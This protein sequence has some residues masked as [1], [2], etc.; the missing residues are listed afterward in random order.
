MILGPQGAVDERLIREARARMDEKALVNP[1]GNAEF[2]RQP[3]L[4]AACVDA[5]WSALREEVRFR[6]HCAGLSDDQ[7]AKSAKFTR[8]GMIR[9]YAER[10]EDGPSLLEMVCGLR[11]VGCCIRLTRLDLPN[12]PVHT[13][14]SRDH[15]DWVVHESDRVRTFLKVTRISRGVSPDD[16]NGRIGAYDGCVASMEEDENGVRFRHVLAVIHALD[17]GLILDDYAER[18]IPPESQEVARR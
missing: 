7:F 15:L 2:L 13:I 14:L 17:I 11:A 12:A 10:P 8:R 3:V 9:F 6:Q 16:L 4:I 18:D 1:D 5:T